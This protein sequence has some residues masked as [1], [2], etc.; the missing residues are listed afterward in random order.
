MYDFTRFYIKFGALNLSKSD[1]VAISLALSTSQLRAY[2]PPPPIS[3][4]LHIILDIT[5]NVSTKKAAYFLRI[6]YH[7]SSFQ[8]RSVNGPSMAPT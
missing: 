4:G 2:T 5:K 3:Y 7:T 8:Y 1:A 6:C